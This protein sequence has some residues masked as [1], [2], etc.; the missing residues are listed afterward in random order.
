VEHG[1]VVKFLTNAENAQ[2]INHLVEDVHEVLMDYQVC[3]QTTDFFY[4][5]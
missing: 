2:K 1:K 3:I 4:H 5:V